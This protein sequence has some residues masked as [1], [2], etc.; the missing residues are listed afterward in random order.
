MNAVT[1]NRKKGLNSPRYLSGVKLYALF[2]L[3]LNQVGLI[4]IPHLFHK[5][6]HQNNIINRLRCY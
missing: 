3:Y 2:N 5:K 6:R 1:I 4:D